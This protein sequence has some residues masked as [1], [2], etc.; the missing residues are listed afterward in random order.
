MTHHALSPYRTIL[1]NR[2]FAVKIS[3]NREKELIKRK[4]S[5]VSSLL[6]LVIMVFS[7]LIHFI[8]SV[9]AS[10][11]PRDAAEAWDAG[12]R[13]IIE[14]QNPVVLQQLHN[15]CPTIDEEHFT[16]NFLTVYTYSMLIPYAYDSDLYGVNDYW[17]TSEETISLGH[18]DCEDQAINLATLIE[19]LYKETYGYIPSNLVWVVLGYI[20]VPGGE[21]GHGWVLVNEGALPKQTVEEIKSVSISEAIINIIL[22]GYVGIQDLY[23][24]IRHELEVNLDLSTLPPKNNRQLSL[25][26]LGERYFELEPTWNLPVSEYYFKK[27]PYTK[28]Y[29]IFNSQGYNLDPKFYPVEQPPYM[30]AEIKN[31][32]FPIWVVVGNIFTVNITIQ[33]YD[34]GIL[35]ADMVVILKNYGVEVARQNAYVFKYWWQIHTFVFNL[36]AIE[37]AQTEKLSVELYW[38]NYWP[39]FVDDWI[40]EDFKN[41]TMETIS[42]KPDLFPYTTFTYPK[43]A[44]EGQLLIFNVLGQNLG[45]MSTG[46]WAINIFI[47][48]VPFDT[49]WV[50]GC[51][52]FSGFQIQSKP[53]IATAGNH[54]VK[55]VVDATGIIS[56]HNETNNEITVPLEVRTNK[57]SYVYS[58]VSTSSDDAQKW[59]NTS[60]GGWQWNLTYSMNIAGCPYVFGSPLTGGEDNFGCGLRFTNM[61]IPQK[62]KITYARLELCAAWDDESPVKTKIHGESTGDA[63]TFSTLANFNAR[64]WTS[65]FIYWDEIPAWKT[66]EWYFSPDISNIIQEI[67]DRSDWVSGN[68]IAIIWE[69]FESRSISYIENSRR[70]WSYDKNPASAPRLLIDYEDIAPP[71]ITVI[72]PENVTYLG[73]VPLVVTINEPVSWIGYSVDSQVNVT[74]SGNVTLTGL[75]EGLHNVVVYAKDTFDNVGTSERVF[76]SVCA[77]E[78][79]NH[80]VVWDGKTFQVVTI[81]NSSIVPVPVLFDPLRKMISFNVTGPSGTLGFCNVAIPKALLNAKSSEWQITIDKVQIDPNI[82]ENATHTFIAFVYF[83]STHSVTIVGTQV[84]LPQNPQV[85]INPISEIIVLGQSVSFTSTITDGTPPYTFQWY[86]NGNPVNGVTSASWI[87]TPTT[88]GIYYIQLKATDANGNIGQSE[89]ARVTVSSVPVGGHSVLISVEKRTDEAPAIYLT[90]I[91]ALSIGFLTIR[92][93]SV[94]K[95]RVSSANA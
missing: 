41:F 88:S 7:S 51:N 31:I 80:Q 49:I 64:N 5:R 10:S 42:N 16:N 2:Y 66:N 57:G 24:Q 77:N 9:S 28:V 93:I 63:L 40:L 1:H 79:I 52:G 30:G 58:Q 23:T 29:A 46:S 69:D 14:P 50:T 90:V 15:L 75:S 81:S 91:I 62:A 47:D 56:E 27:Y 68:S 78:T 44:S 65:T 84:G 35:G 60:G 73:C 11:H 12:F 54:S 61:T 19:A 6:I 45:P 53:W 92:R 33:N 83:H 32:A 86:L 26:Y 22:G 13:G 38:H 3:K 36:Q 76:F 89:T 74:I 20:V 4:V 71:S 72:S 94:R 25:L 55:V 70:A 95:R 34:C 82:S 17:Q 59:N 85:S 67:V 37:P 43:S 48:N 8:P 39:P 87:F 21:G 18:G